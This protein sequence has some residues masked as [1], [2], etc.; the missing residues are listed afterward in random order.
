MEWCLY[1]IE[2]KLPMLLKRQPKKYYWKI[3]SSDAK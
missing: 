3:I 2:D 1:V